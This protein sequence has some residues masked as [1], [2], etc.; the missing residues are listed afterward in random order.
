M[1]NDQFQW[2]PIKTAP[3]DGRRFVVLKPQ[4]YRSSD[5]KPDI[6]YWEKKMDRLIFDNWLEGPQPTH[7]MPLPPAP[8]E[9]T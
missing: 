3:K 8:E 2:Q 1:S 5:Y 6:C 9:T 7:W 4:R